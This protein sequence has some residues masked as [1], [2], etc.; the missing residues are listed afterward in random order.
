[1]SDF[2]AKMHKIIFRLG[3]CPCWRSLQHSPKPQAGGFKG[4]VLLRGEE[5]K[6]E[7]KG[8]LFFVDLRPCFDVQC[9]SNVADV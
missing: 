9:S 4:S 8:P 1:M 5:G 6:R 2:K 3:L 7:W